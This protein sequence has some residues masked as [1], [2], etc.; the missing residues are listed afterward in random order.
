MASPKLL[1][2]IAILAATRGRMAASWT[3]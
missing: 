2:C 1:D 3:Q